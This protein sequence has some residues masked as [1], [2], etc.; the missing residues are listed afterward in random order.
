MAQYEWILG[1]PAATQEVYEWVLGDPTVTIDNTVQPLEVNVL[2]TDNI[3]ITD[4]SA[5]SISTLEVSVYDD[6]DVADEV[7]IVASVIGVL[8]VNVADDVVLSDGISAQISI[9]EILVVDNV[10]ISDETN[11]LIPVYEIFVADNIEVTDYTEIVNG[12]QL[13]IFVYDELGLT[14]VTTV[15]ATPRDI[16]EYLLDSPAC[17]LADYLIH[18]GKMTKPSL[19]DNWS[20]YVAHLP[21]GIGVSDNAGVTYDNSPRFD[22]KTMS[23][24]AVAHYAVKLMI[25]CKEYR[26]GWQKINNIA[27]ALDEISQQVFTKDETNVYLIQSVSR[28]GVTS[29]GLEEGTKRKTILS[30]NCLMALKSI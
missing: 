2:V 28:G 30:M 16:S 1:E 15:T 20:M 7:D 18:T 3:G 19:N 11:V 26:E 12:T 10:R 27:D 9:L 8:E 13:D 4:I 22:V 14:D 24:E 17:I 23:G 25:R 6:I 5:I 21:D 29:L